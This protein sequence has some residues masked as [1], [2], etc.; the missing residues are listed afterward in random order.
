M[1]RC[2]RTGSMGRGICHAHGIYLVVE[3][4]YREFQSVNLRIGL[5]K[6]LGEDLT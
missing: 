5:R 1:E 6:V 2:G 3:K 4:I